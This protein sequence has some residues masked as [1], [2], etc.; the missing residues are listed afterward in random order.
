MIIG[1]YPQLLQ[2]FLSITCGLR[3]SDVIIID[4]DSMT[5][6]LLAFQASL[7]DEDRVLKVADDTCIALDELAFSDTTGTRWGE[8]Q[9]PMATTRSAPEDPVQASLEPQ[10][11][12]N[13]VMVVSK[14]GPPM[15]DTAAVQAVAN[16]CLVDADEDDE[17]YADHSPATAAE[18]DNDSMSEDEPDLTPKPGSTT[19]EKEDDLTVK[20]TATPL[21]EY[22]ENQTILYGGFSSLFF[23]GTG[24]LTKGH[25]TTSNV[26]H[27]L[28]H[29]TNVFAD[30]DRFIFLLFNQLQRRQAALD[31][32]VKIKNNPKAFREFSKVV[33]DEGFLDLCRQ[34]LARAKGKA[35]KALLKKVAP[36]LKFLGKQVN[37]LCVPRLPCQTPTQHFSHPHHANKQVP[38]SPQE[39][40]QSTS[41]LYAI[42]QRYG[43]VSSF[44][45]LSFDDTHN[46]LVMRLSVPS[47][48]NTTFPAT[49]D[50]FLRHLTAKNASMPYGREGK[51]MDLTEYGLHHRIARAA[52]SATRVF[53]RMMQNVSHHLL[54]KPLQNHTRATSARQAGV[55]GNMTA[56]G[57]CIEAQGRGTLHAHLLLCGLLGPDILQ[58]CA[59]Y[60]QLRDAVIEWIDTVFVGHVELRAHLLGLVRRLHDFPRQHLS[61]QPIPVPFTPEWEKRHATNMNNTQFHGHRKTCTKG[62]F[63]ESGCRLA[64]PSEC[65]D[66]TCCVH[67]VPIFKSDEKTIETVIASTD[68]PHEKHKH[69]KD[70]NRLKEPLP[71]VDGRPLVWEN[72][73]PDVTP[74]PAMAPT[75]H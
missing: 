25:L 39:R 52:V 40:K 72:K 65:L 75:D 26:S 54:G 18:A 36:F 53:L 34:A 63:G 13:S 55:L 60:P 35:E 28:N 70:R 27:L 1:I 12:M 73:R 58:A 7:L 42:V 3:Y 51:T 74:T 22:T 15:D 4:T 37:T 2:P 24:L 50:G 67:I 66:D 5:S 59:A 10:P 61:Y 29:F 49:P 14:H 11:I 21:N 9:A 43:I 30:D 19:Q 48:D 38:F 69:R 68:L 41:N 45:T 44:L 46:P 23:C 56:M 62:P 20:R 57:G 64:K 71:A 16:A 31:V 6:Q 32:S 47:H 8:D 17:D 33:Q